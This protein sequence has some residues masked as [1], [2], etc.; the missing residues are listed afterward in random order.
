MKIIAEQEI[1]YDEVISILKR[2]DVI[3]YPTDT[4]YALGCDATNETAVKKIFTI[5]LRK[6]EKTL[7]LITGDKDMAEEWLEFSEKAQELADT[8]WPGPLS[9]TLPIKKLGLSKYAVQDGFVSMRVPDNVVAAKISEE[10]DKPIVS[11]SANTS[12]TGAC[13]TIRDIKMSL[14]E[15]VNQVSFIIDVGELPNKGVSTVARVKNQEIEILREGVIKI[16]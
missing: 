11:T 8:Y 1:D 9:L 16:K 4:A 13:Y 5:K 3:I 7:S 6:P 14:G 12:G 10:L 15:K 2:G